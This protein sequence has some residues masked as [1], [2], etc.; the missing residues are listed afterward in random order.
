V[1]FEP[2]FAH[3]KRTLKLLTAIH[4]LTSPSI[5]SQWRLAVKRGLQSRRAIGGA[6]AR[7]HMLDSAT[8]AAAVA[9]IPTCR[10]LVGKPES[11]RSPTTTWTTKE[12][13]RSAVRKDAMRDADAKFDIA[14]RD[15]RRVHFR[16]DLT[17][18]TQRRNHNIWKI[19]E[20]HSNLSG[21]THRP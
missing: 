15:E 8:Y 6:L 20:K 16:G 14:K 11:P 10:D 5:M 12:A 13:P 9:A 3:Q 1:S 2:V 21:S 4:L 18:R 19:F 17:R 7:S